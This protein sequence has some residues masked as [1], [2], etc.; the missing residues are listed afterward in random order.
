MQILPST[1]GSN[2]GKSLFDSIESPPQFVQHGWDDISASP[3]GYQSVIE[4]ANKSVNLLEYLY[5]RMA[6]EAV[7]S[8]S[9]W[10]YRS[11]CPFHKHGEERTA[12]FFI[13]VEQNRFYCQA[14]SISGGIVEY[15]AHTYKRPI[16]MVAQHIIKCLNGNYVI[17][18]ASLKKAAE[19]KKFQA[20]MLK[21]SDLYRSFLRKNITDE[22]AISYLNRCFESFDEVM[23]DNQETIENS[24]DE[25]ICH[26]NDYLRKYTEK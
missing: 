18:A 10:A 9:A 17:E 1:T 21:L 22:E 25:I 20:N 12:S 8:N 3:E 23:E 24:M 2:S 6:L 19:R 5:S 15:I 26:M 16:I 14:C 4:Q 13:N 11:R 7:S